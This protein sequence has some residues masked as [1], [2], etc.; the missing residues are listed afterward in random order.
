MEVYPYVEGCT[1][2]QRGISQGNSRWG[3]PSPEY[4]NGDRGNAVECTQ[5]VD[6]GAY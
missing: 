5:E 2:E 1:T 3:S 4:D 6:G